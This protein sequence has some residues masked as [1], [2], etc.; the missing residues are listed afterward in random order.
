MVTPAMGIAMKCPMYSL[1]ENGAELGGHGFHLRL[2]T[3]QGSKSTKL[4][5][6]KVP[7][8]LISYRFARLGDRYVNFDVVS[9]L[10]PRAAGAFLGF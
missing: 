8:S 5:L 3:F 9:C 10:L 2:C 7:Y 6:P 4:S 1:R